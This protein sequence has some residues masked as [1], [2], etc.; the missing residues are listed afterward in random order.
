MMTRIGLLLII[1]CCAFLQ[2]RWLMAQQD[3]TSTDLLQRSVQRLSPTLD[4]QE[5]SLCN[6][7]MRF[8]LWDFSHT[9]MDAN[10]YNDKEDEALVQQLGDRRK[11]YGLDIASL[12][13]PTPNSRAWGNVYYDHTD[14]SNINMNLNSDYA[15][16]YPY[17]TAD[18]LGPAELEGETYSFSGGYAQQLGERYLFGIS[19]STRNVQEYR[20]SDPRP[21]NRISDIEI[22]L[23]GG[24][25][26]PADYA[27]GL[28]LGF[29]S[30]K[31]ASMVSML[32]D[33][34]NRLGTP[35]YSMTGLGTALSIANDESS[36]TYAAQTRTVGLDMY[37]T[38]GRG[39]TAHIS[40][41]FD[42]LNKTF[43]LSEGSTTSINEASRGLNGSPINNVLTMQEDR[44]QARLG[45]VAH[46]DDHRWSL[47]GAYTY[48]HRIGTE[49][50]MA[51]SMQEI[52]GIS[53][54]HTNMGMVP[55]YQE[56]ITQL[57]LD[58]VYEKGVRKR[59]H[60][61]PHIAYR[62]NDTRY[63]QPSRL[64]DYER[65]A[66]AAQVGVS[67]LHKKQLF[68]VLLEGGYDQAL[69]AAIDID[70][71]LEQVGGNKELTYGWL[72]RFSSAV[73]MANYRFLANDNS[74]LKA[75]ARWEWQ[76]FSNKSLF[77]QPTYQQGWYTDNVKSSYWQVKV[78][79]VL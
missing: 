31:Q 72:N 29:T 21:R 70:N 73:E 33:S 63:A 40:Y 75:S 38:R 44:L 14:R 49:I 25:M 43:G 37:P 16:I 78:G 60:V 65:L 13:T 28:S 71:T 51:S 46:V 7:A 52:Q 48:R 50:L 77:L 20:Q 59:C 23:G 54:N 67:W 15:R 11:G 47:Q 8:F 1:S 26:L 10:A 9:Q 66:Y 79:M 55:Y 24:Y 27:L 68:H 56:N 45:W 39:L 18:T 58:G 41:A 69:S 34:R 2:P 12:L 5:Q 76:L 62:K 36:F 19:A 57:R 74:Y 6:P 53:T 42:E 61:K 3:S 32:S 22:L 4:L 35:L 64:L 17:V 30:Y